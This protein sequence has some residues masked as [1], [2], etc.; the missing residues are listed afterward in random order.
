MRKKI[1]VDTNILISGIFFKGN[2]SKLLSIV[3]VDFFTSDTAVS[4]LKEVVKR[5]FSSSKV[6]NLRLALLETEIA[7]GD[8]IKIVQEKEY[9]HKIR[10]SKKIVRSKKDVKVLAAALAS[11]AE[12]FVTGD[13]DFFTPEVRKRIKVL[14]TKELLRELSIAV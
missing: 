5:K 9:R 3:D 7:L 11:G 6:E 12:Y 4:E 13:K 14:R 1:F 8:F 10:E 2:E